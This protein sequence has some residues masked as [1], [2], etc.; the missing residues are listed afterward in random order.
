VAL[1]LEIRQLGDADW[2]T[3]RRLR[4]EALADSPA[5][6]WATWEDEIGFSAEWWIEFTRSVTWFVGF[7]AE[8][9]IGLIGCLQRDPRPEE[10]EVIGMWVRADERGS[11]TADALLAAA[12]EW[13]TRHGL[14]SLSLGVTDVNGRARHFYERHGFR[15]TGERV[16]LPG[17]RG[18]VEEWMRREVPGASV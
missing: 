10:P 12:V 7:R 17:D 3:L 14:T 15:A 1:V 11:G 6:F 5:A 2:P 4:L 18:G 16:P 9:P 8:S 13:A